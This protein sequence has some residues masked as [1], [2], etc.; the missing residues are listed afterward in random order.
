[1]KALRTIDH[2]I[3]QVKRKSKNIWIDLDT[4]E[5]Y[6]LHEDIELLY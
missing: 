3:V 6:I 4:E 5:K 1:M 2:E